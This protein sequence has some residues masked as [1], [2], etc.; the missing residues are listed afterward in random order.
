MPVAQRGQL[1]CTHILHRSQMLRRIYGKM[2]IGMINIGQKVNL[3][4]HSEPVIRIISRNQ[5][6]GFIRQFGL[7]VAADFF[8]ITS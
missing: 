1:V 5:T 4:D 3:A 6:A 8:K 7:G 2:L